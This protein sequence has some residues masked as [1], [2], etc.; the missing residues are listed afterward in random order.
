VASNFTVEELLAPLAPNENALHSFF[1]SNVDETMLQEIAAADYGWKADECCAML[2]PVLATGQKPAADSNLQE[3]L[4]LIRWSEPE[5]PAWSPGGH[6]LR[7]H[8]MRLFACVALV[9]QSS[10]TNEADTLAQLTASSIFLGPAVARAS[11]SLLAWRFLKGLGESDDAAFLA[12]AILLLA[13]HV[14]HGADRGPWLKDLAAWVESEEASARD[15]FSK[16]E[17]LFGVTFYTQ[18]E[19]VW[20]SLAQRI[21]VNPESPHPPEA[22]QALRLLGELVAERL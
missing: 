4:E 3:V 8:W 15:R 6:G 14:E 17:W 5:D 7:G 1:Q 22:D 11:A 18:R 13:A 10:G 9:R 20:R 2:Q 21:L 16:Q 19:A 12:F